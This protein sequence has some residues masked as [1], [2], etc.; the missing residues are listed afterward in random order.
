MSS[1]AAYLAHPARVEA[2]MDQPLSRWLWLVTR[3]APE[4][5]GV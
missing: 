1:V 2:R 3:P 4:P 5:G